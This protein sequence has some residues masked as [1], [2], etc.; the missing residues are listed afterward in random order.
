MLKKVLN[1]KLSDSRLYNFNHGH[2]ESTY[3][4]TLSPEISVEN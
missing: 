4:Q 1:L 2:G 3:Q